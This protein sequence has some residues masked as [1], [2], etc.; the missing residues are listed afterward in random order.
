VVYWQLHT[1]VRNRYL[2]PLQVY[3]ATLDASLAR[4]QAQGEA[5]PES[6]KKHSEKSM[7]LKQI[8]R[9]LQPQRG[10]ANVSGWG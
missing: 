9:V 5:T 10:E 4:Q 2:T 6:V 3:T 7:L 1:Y 8:L